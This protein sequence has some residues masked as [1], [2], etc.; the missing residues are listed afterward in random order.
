M[1]EIRDPIVAGYLDK[2]EQSPIDVARSILV[3][4]KNSAT[5]K[6]ALAKTLFEM[7]PRSEASYSE[8]GEKFLRH[9]V[10]HHKIC[11]NQHTR[12][13][14]K[15][16]QAIER[17]LI[18]EMTWS[19]LFSV[20]EQ[21]IYNNV[22]DAFHVI[23]GGSLEGKYALFEHDKS[24][25]KIVLT[26]NLN[27]LQ[28]EDRLKSDLLSESEARWRVVEEAWRGN[29]SPMMLLDER[30][31]LFFTTVGDYRI[32][33]RSAVSTLM[34]YQFGKCFYCNCILDESLSS[35][36]DQFPD[37]DHV[38]PISLLVREFPMNVLNPNGVWNL[39]LAC[40]R[41]NRGHKGKG[42]S[43]PNI[44]HYEHLLDRNVYFTRE[45]KHAMRYSILTSLSVSNHI[46]VKRRMQEIYKPFN[47]FPKWTP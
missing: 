31:K 20:A 9:L 6:F 41:C 25:K 16:S 8:I 30:E 10:E 19:E 43:V 3:F 39:V 33:L 28:S 47:F 40:K 35:H 21:S 27:A 42:G 1:G 29:I 44:M 18:E 46:E 2:S 17:F 36:E 26:G 15:L 14:T 22:F 23:G 38:L 45:H 13:A 37:V 24:R 7:T 4:G 11:P 5:Y 12:G 34:P 32:N